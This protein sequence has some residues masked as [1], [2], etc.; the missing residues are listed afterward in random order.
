MYSYSR[1]VGT[2]FLTRLMVTLEVLLEVEVAV[3]LRDLIG[4][5]G[6]SRNFRVLCWV[7]MSCKPREEGSVWATEYWINEIESP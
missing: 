2:H 6:L 5:L 3:C 7:F 4:F 1:R